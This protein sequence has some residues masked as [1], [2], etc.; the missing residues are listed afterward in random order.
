MSRASAQ[1]RAYFARV[2]RQN[3]E[4]EQDPPPASLAEMLDR[5]EEM[6]RS[7]GS[8]ALPGVARDDEGDLASHLAYLER[9]R[10]IAGRG[11]KRT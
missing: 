10:Q 3:R 7:L 1:D 11:T 2:S 6:R 5:L 4:L 8:L 9:C